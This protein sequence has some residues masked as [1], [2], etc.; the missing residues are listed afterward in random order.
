MTRAEKKLKVLELIARGEE[1]GKK[2]YSTS[3]LIPAIMKGIPN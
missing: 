1:I 2:E 3:G